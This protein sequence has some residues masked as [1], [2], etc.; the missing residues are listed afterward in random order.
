M[1]KKFAEFEDLVSS[2]ENDTDIVEKFGELAP[3]E[4]WQSHE[5]SPL[6]AKNQPTTPERPKNEDDDETPTPRYAKTTREGIKKHIPLK[7]SPVGNVVRNPVAIPG[8]SA[9]I[10]AGISPRRRGRRANGMPPPP[11]NAAPAETD[12]ITPKKRENIAGIS[13]SIP[14]AYEDPITQRSPKIYATNPEPI[15]TTEKTPTPEATQ[16]QNLVAKPI[17]EKKAETEIPEQK[18]INETKNNTSPNQPDSRR[19]LQIPE[20][21]KTSAGEKFTISAIKRAKATERYTAWTMSVATAT[22]TFTILA[23]TYI[24]E[25]YINGKHDPNHVAHISTVWK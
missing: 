5:N 19:K 18:E 24:A 15:P 17:S 14:D 2:L 8:G 22:L 6:D 25:K 9:T 1:E 7:S 4:E 10:P 16:I 11:K 13:K 21:I 12:Q 20:V 3:A 23:S